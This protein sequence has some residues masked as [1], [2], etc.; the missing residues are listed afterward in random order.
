MADGAI[1]FVCMDH[2]HMA[3]LLDAGDAAFTS[4]LNICVWDKGVGGMGSLYRSQHELVAVFKQGEAPHCNNVALGKNGRNRTNI[5]SF[6]GMAGLGKGRKKALA[7]HPTVKPVAL[8]GEPLLDVTAP[9]DIVLDPFG[10]SGTTLIA[11]E[12]TGRRACL[13]E[14]DPHYVDCIIV[15][16]QRLTGQTAELLERRDQQGL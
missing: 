7:M 8:V 15:R 4:R 13:V 11:A 9:G 14:L 2:A 16:W 12:R 3:E 10:G 5:W 1:A 6:S